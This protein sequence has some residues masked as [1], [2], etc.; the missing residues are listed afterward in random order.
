MSGEDGSP[1]EIGWEFEV[2]PA[3]DELYLEHAASDTTYVLDAEGGLRVPGEADVGSELNTLRETLTA[4]LRADGDEREAVTDG[5]QTGPCSI[6][7][8][9]TTGEVTIESDADISLESRGT[10]SLDAS[11]IELSADG[12]AV[13][14]ASGVLTL[15]GALIKLN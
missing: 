4:P 9:E 5:G 10:I 8:D 2:D 14:D 1:E 11:Q 7:C 3:G 12:N 13:V 15:Q 6:E